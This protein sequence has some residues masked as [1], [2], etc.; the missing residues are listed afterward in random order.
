MEARGPCGE[1]KHSRQ[2]VRWSGGAVSAERGERGRQGRGRG[3]RGR[4]AG[5]TGCQV[6]R[7]C[8]LRDAAMHGHQGLRLA[9]GRTASGSDWHVVSG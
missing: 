7:G 3:G 5:Q 6:G 9:P 2:V 8:C 4:G 1:G